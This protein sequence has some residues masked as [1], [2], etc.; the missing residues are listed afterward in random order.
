MVLP[1]RSEK[2]NKNDNQRAGNQK[3]TEMPGMLRNTLAGRLLD[4]VRDM[5]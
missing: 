4:E 5:L 3:K 1:E 2:H